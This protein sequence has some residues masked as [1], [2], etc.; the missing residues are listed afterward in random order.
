MPTNVAHRHQVI[1]ICDASGDH[2]AIG[3]LKPKPTT[4]AD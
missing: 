1:L 4:V 3:G 2:G